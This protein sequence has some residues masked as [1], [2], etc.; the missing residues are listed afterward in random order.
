VNHLPQPPADIG[1]MASATTSSSETPAGAKAPETAPFEEHPPSW[2]L[3]TRLGSIT[4]AEQPPTPGADTPP[5]LGAQLL[6]M[7]PSY[8]DS[9]VEEPTHSPIQLQP[10]QR[11]FGGSL[12]R[13][14][15]WATAEGGGAMQLDRQ[16]HKQPL[17]C[18]THHP[19]QK[20]QQQLH[21]HHWSAASQAAAVVVACMGWVLVSSAAIL[22]N[23]KI[24]VDLS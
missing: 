6:L 5:L 22:I 23:K 3:S 18:S 19:S 21:T 2:G 24:M 1:A 12:L 17:P 20:Q 7:Q 10:P 4:A 16:Q 14:P 11:C 9:V 8:S 15:S 13:Q